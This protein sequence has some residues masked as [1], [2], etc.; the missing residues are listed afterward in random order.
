MSTCGQDINV[1]LEDVITNPLPQLPAIPPSTGIG[2]VI[3]IGD[4]PTSG[5]IEINPGGSLTPVR[6]PTLSSYRP[7]LGDLAYLMKQGPQWIALGSLSTRNV[8]GSAPIDGSNSDGSWWRWTFETG[9]PQQLGW[10][11]TDDTMGATAFL[12]RSLASAIGFAPAPHGE[13]VAR[14]DLR[15][16]SGC[17]SALVY[18]TSPSIPV[19]PGQVWEVSATVRMAYE[20][21]NDRQFG[22][23]LVA[24]QYPG[25]GT[26]V[27][28]ST[29]AATGINWSQLGDTFTVAAGQTAVQ[30]LVQTN[31]ESYREGCPE[32][33]DTFSATV[34]VDD[35]YLRRIS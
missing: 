12:G 27:S 4:W 28:R 14:W 15:G 13:Y 2:E 7:Q 30:I 25:G 34:G 3:G 21:T 29:P 10:A 6:V 1:E 22:Y 35:V 9:T 20:L 16:T 33:E 18:M 31:V 11:A 8:G 26:G 32:V 17:G 19:S 24:A 23:V 5:L